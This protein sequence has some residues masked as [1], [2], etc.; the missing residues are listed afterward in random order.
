MCHLTFLT[1]VQIFYLLCHGLKDC[2][3]WIFTVIFIQQCPRVCTGIIILLF[4][5][6]LNI[7]ENEMGQEKLTIK[8]VGNTIGL[9][10]ARELGSLPTVHA[11]FETP[12][13]SVKWSEVKW[14]RKTCQLFMHLPK[15]HNFTFQLNLLSGKLMC[16]NDKLGP[17]FSLELSIKF[18]MKNAI[19]N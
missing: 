2:S 18:L 11:K 15:T 13:Q 7:Q 10:Q 14:S 1:S 8:W 5:V 17:S 16:K 6:F 9:V 3:S 4:L 12:F 19:A